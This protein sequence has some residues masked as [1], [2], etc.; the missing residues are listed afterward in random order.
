M[1]ILAEND[2]IDALMTPED[3]S[4]SLSSP[5]KVMLDDSSSS[6]GGY[7][8]A[9]ILWALVALAYLF[10]IGAVAV[11]IGAKE[12]YCLRVIAAVLAMAIP[13]LAIVAVAYI[14]WRREDLLYMSKELMASQIK[15]MREATTKDLIEGRPT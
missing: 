2:I 3:L 7:A 1:K 12:L 8:K 15:T 11:I 4:Q 13:L 6:G 9:Q 5:P 14:R 10:E